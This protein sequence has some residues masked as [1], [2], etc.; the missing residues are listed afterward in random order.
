MEQS[1][2]EFD[3]K[4]RHW[5]SKQVEETDQVRGPVP[6]SV[7]VGGVV[8]EAE[9]GGHQKVVVR[10]LAEKIFCFF[11]WSAIFGT[12]TSIEWYLAL[13]FHWHAYIIRHFPCRIFSLQLADCT[14]QILED[15]LM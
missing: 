7:G 15:K 13:A 3:S 14:C 12:I 8:G 5:S 2:R 10:N 9:S 6:A 4:S 1:R 11:K